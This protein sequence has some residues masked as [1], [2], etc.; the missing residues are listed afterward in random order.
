MK[1]ILFL[2]LP[3]F[4][5][6]CANNNSSDIEKKNADELK[7]QYEDSI[8]RA[9]VME[10]RSRVKNTEEMNELIAQLEGKTNIVK[11]LRVEIKV[12]EEKLENLKTPKLLRT[13]AERE[14]QIRNQIYVIDDLKTQLSAEENE[15]NSL[16]NKI[17]KMRS[18]LGLSKLKNA[19][20][21]NSQGNIPEI[22]F[23]TELADSIAK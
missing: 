19:D 6:S 14:S 10:E 1:R 18:K 16:I 4:L 7:S 8:K 22:N 20:A 23:D 9:A 11:G 2:A 17:N 13:P 3:L 5:F 15:L 12:Q 21:L